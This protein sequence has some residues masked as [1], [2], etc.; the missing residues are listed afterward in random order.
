MI[1]GSDQVHWLNHQK[2]EDDKFSRRLTQEE[3]SELP[4]EIIWTGSQK[5][6]FENDEKECFTLVFTI[7]GNMNEMQDSRY[8]SYPLGRLH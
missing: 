4:L 2:T 6:V 8:H 7:I 5:F 3:I 1:A